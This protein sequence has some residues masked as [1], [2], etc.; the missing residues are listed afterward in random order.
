MGEAT[1][2]NSYKIVPGLSLVKL[3]E[4]KMVGEYLKAFDD[5]EGIL[6]AHPN[7]ILKALS[8]KLDD[9]KTFRQREKL[10]QTAYY[11]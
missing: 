3:P 11:N 5:K 4:D 10:S 8:K 1:V 7:Y 6:Y 2:T 9:R